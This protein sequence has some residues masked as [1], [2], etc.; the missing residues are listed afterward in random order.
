[1]KKPDAII[2]IALW[3]F[4]SAFMAVVGIAAVALVAYPTVKGLHLYGIAHLGAMFGL[5]VGMLML[6]FYII[7]AIIGAVGL[8]SGREWGRILTI[9]L[10]ALSLF[11]IPFGTIIGI[12][13][14][15]YLVKPEAREYFQPTQK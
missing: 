7:L 13:V 15:M 12:L 9:V 1:M 3:Q 5:A 6:V 11:A 4:F 8:L 10:A 14:I 2:L